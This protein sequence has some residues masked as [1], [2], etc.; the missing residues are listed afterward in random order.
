MILN[1]GSFPL[2]S[3]F[4]KSRTIASSNATVFPEPV[5]A[6]TTMWWSKKQQKITFFVES[7]FL[8]T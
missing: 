6:D 8:T 3:K 1:D 5:G 2:N 7:S 4:I